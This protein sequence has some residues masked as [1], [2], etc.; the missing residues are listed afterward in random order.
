MAAETTF[1]EGWEWPEGCDDMAV[2]EKEL[3]LPV[4]EEVASA[5]IVPWQELQ[6]QQEGDQVGR[7]ASYGQDYA[8]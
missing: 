7:E 1:V 6:Q 3:K 4:P 5:P 2:D 8:P